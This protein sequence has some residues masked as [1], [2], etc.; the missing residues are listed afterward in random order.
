MA[1]W[2]WLKEFNV[3]S[4]SDP[5]DDVAK[6]VFQLPDTDWQLPLELILRFLV[7]KDDLVI[8]HSL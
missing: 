4:E 1:D 3:W 5:V 6:K 2:V 8:D 7:F